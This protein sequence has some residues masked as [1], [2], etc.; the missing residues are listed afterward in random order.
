M[1]WTDLIPGV[2][3]IL[4]GL[5]SG[6]GGDQEAADALKVLQGS[7][8]TYG[9]TPYSNLPYSTPDMY[10]TPEQLTGA[11]VNEDPALRNMQIQSLNELKNI[12]E[13][14]FTPAQQNAYTQA[15]R[16]AGQQAK[17]STDAI[18]AQMA[19][20]G[21]SGSG[22]S[23]ALQQMA[24]QSAADRMSASTLQAAQDEAVARQKAN[25]DLMT[26]SGQ[27]RNQDYQVN[28]TNA[29]ILNEFNKLNS[30][31]AQDTRNMNTDLTN[32]TRMAN[33]DI[34]RNTQ[35][36]NVDLYNQRAINEAEAQTNK[37]QNIARQYNLNAGREDA[38]SA[39]NAGI[40]QNVASGIGQAMA[41]EPKETA[42]EKY[43]RSQTP[44]GVK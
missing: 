22:M 8:T 32:K 43:L 42:W 38:G 31:N 33:T 10:M 12:Q 40:F 16:A 35:N 36:A 3:S 5:F 24:R 27:M 15:S 6:N 39:A 2:G 34:Q 7:P 25:M 37:N 20:Q 17:G 29:N 4:G 44:T 23:A 1:G 41:P 19:N 28:N 30:K 18:I 9:I 14:G 21:R 13:Q 26:G 11:Q